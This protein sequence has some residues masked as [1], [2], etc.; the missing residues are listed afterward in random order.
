MRR[1]VSVT[2]GVLSA[3]IARDL[4]DTGRPRIAKPF[5][6]TQLEAVLSTEG[7]IRAGAL[8]S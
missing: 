2:G 5:A 7:L 3:D 6:L 4:A 8:T 1:F